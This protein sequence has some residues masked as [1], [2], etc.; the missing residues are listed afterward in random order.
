MGDFMYNGL[1]IPGAMQCVVWR[2]IDL[3]RGVGGNYR[4]DLHMPMLLFR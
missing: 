3:G 4:V 1:S 2:S